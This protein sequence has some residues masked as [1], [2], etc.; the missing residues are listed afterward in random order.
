[1]RP[2][3]GK[4]SRGDSGDSLLAIE[5][6]LKA[7]RQPVLFEPGEESVA[8]NA[9]SY[10]LTVR[11]GALTLEAWSDKRNLVR[12]VTGVRQERRGRLELTVERFGKRSGTLLLVDAAAPRNHA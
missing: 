4:A 1:M 9:G 6:F 10:A 8:L 12:R 5:R 7:S 3:A 2:A 11:G